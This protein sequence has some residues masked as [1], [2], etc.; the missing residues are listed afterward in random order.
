[1]ISLTGTVCELLSNQMEMTYL[2]VNR[3]SVCYLVSFYRTYNNGDEDGVFE[4]D[5]R[6]IVA[7]C[8]H[9]YKYVIFSFVNNNLAQSWRLLH[10]NYVIVM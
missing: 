5:F 1:M 8:S 6:P 7:P 9:I 4:R 3:T 2:K 10:L